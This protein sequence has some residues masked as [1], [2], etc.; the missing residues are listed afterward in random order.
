MPFPLLCD[1]EHRVIAQWDILNARERGGIAKPAAF[2]IDPSRIVRFAAT[3]DVVRRVP[4]AEIVS[5]LQQPS[6][7]QPV[8]RTVH[9]PLPSHWIKAIRNNIGR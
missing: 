8:R 9:L 5:L 3:D 7:T 4:A 2:V 6:A 1:T